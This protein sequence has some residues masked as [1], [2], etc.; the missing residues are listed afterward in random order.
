M[1]ASDRSKV[2]ALLPSA[3]ITGMLYKKPATTKSTMIT[4]PGIS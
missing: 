4:T 2:N 3:Q 1:I